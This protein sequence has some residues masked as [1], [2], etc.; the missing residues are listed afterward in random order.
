MSDRSS[1][2]LTR[3][4]FHVTIT[5]APDHFDNWTD[6]VRDGGS[7]VQVW[8]RGWSTLGTGKDHAGR[9]RTTFTP[10]GADFDQPERPTQC[11]GSW[12]VVETRGQDRGEYCRVWYKL[13]DVGDRAAFERSIRDMATGIV[14][15]YHVRVDVR[16]EAA[17][18]VVGS[19][20]LGGVWLRYNE[21]EGEA[22]ITA[23]D[24]ADMI[25]EAIHEARRLAPGMVDRLRYEADAIAFTMRHE[26]DAI[27][28]VCADV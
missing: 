22:L 7:I 26:A 13:A 1:T 2:T 9:P 14:S 24:D 12:A 11:D 15:P 18:P 27:A 25:D 19:Y 17:G 5:A 28:A 21:A 6:L 10:A 23:A 8:D 4:G 3:Q 16:A 20:A